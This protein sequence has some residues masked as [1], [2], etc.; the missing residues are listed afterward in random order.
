MKYTFSLTDLD[1][2][3]S[4]WRSLYCNETKNDMFILKNKEN[5]AK[6]CMSD[7]TFCLLNLHNDDKV[8]KDIAVFVFTGECDN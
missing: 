8:L 4:K 2:T 5:F 7:L 6:K 3:W 1:V